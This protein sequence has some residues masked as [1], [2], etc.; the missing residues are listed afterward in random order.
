MI[1]C[2]LFDLQ[3]PKK[4][5][6][7]RKSNTAKCFILFQSQLFESRKSGWLQWQ[8]G[9]NVQSRNVARQNVFGWTSR[10]NLE[11]NQFSFAIRLISIYNLFVFLFIIS[12]LW[13]FFLINKGLTNADSNLILYWSEIFLFSLVIIFQKHIFSSNWKKIRKASL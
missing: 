11:R 8:S 10:W 13:S 7:I 9:W 3:L 1:F 2:F 12:Q 6:I 4:P 5:W